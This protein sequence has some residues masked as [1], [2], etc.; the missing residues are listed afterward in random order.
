[1]NAAALRVAYS[2]SSGFNS[3]IPFS[4]NSRAKSAIA[5]LALA[6]SFAGI[7]AS[8]ANS[9]SARSSRERRK[10]PVPEGAVRAA[11]SDD[12]LLRRN[13]GKKHRAGRFVQSQYI[14]ERKQQAA[15]DLC[16]LRTV[17]VQAFK[18]AFHLRPVELV[19]D[20]GDARM[21]VLSARPRNLVQQ[22][23]AKH[24]F[25]KA[26]GR[27]HDELVAKQAPHQFVAQGLLKL[28]QYRRG[29]GCGRFGKDECRDLRMLPAEI[30]GDE[31][32]GYLGEPRPHRLIH[33]RTDAGHDLP[34]LFR[35]RNTLKQFLRL[36]RRACKTA[37]GYNARGE[38]YDKLVDRQPRIAPR[39]EAERAISRISSSSKCFNM[40]DA[41]SSPVQ[42][43]C[44][45]LFPDRRAFSREEWRR[46]GWVPSIVQE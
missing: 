6:T 27:F 42:R 29:Q 8:S 2:A 22:L 12:N 28:A 38:L 17:K 44:R 19:D 14:L 7:E 1:M 23:V 33:S 35:G 46:K 5:R 32:R 15:D 18:H 43:E 26:K 24:L 3:I 31:R 13:I 16:F 4:N 39:S 25:K 9:C 10:Y 40:R 11:Q 41:C 37:F 21:R 45:P 20:V 34:D 36:I 30:L